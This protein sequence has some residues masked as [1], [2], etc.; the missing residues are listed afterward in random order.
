LLLPALVAERWGDWSMAALLGPAFAGLML[1]RPGLPPVEAEEVRQAAWMDLQI[2][3]R[4]LHW[5]W[6]DYWH[7]RPLRLLSTQGVVLIPMANTPNGPMPHLWIGDRSLLGEG[8]A[9]ERPEYVLVSGL[10]EE[11]V[12]R[13]LGA[14]DEVVQGEG[15]TLWFKHGKAPAA[16]RKR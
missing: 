15:L 5:G 11:A 3:G 6:G 13:R 14:P 9:I 1:L 16:K 7:A 12:R 10:D 8:A 2:G 4:G